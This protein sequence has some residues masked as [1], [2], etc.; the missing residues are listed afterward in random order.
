MAGT[1][2]GLVYDFGEAHRVQMTLRSF[3]IAGTTGYYEKQSSAALVAALYGW[4]WLGPGLRFPLILSF[5]TRRS[6]SVESLT[7]ERFGSARLQ[8]LFSPWLARRSL[9]DMFR[10]AQ[11][12]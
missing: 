4:N 12:R 3:L 7:I 5:C 9:P 10:W 1:A 2:L 6:G 11:A 8:Q